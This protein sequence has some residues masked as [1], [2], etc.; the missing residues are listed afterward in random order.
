MRDW[1]KR[2]RAWID[3]VLHVLVFGGGA[4]LLGAG[5]A[6]GW[7]IV[8]ELTPLH[9]RIGPLTIGQWPPGKVLIVME[10]LDR[11]GRDV[12]QRGGPFCV[13]QSGRVE[14]LRTDLLFSLGAI[15]IGDALH[16]LVVRGAM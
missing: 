2:H 8:Y 13:Y 10:W 5:L 1:Y 3:Q 7:L 12:W 15:A 6:I 9:W 4:I 14:D 16:A 11:G